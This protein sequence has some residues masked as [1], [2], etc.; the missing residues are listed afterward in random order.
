M[1][2]ASTRP[3]SRIGAPGIHPDEAAQHPLARGNNADAT[4][5]KQRLAQAV[6]LRWLRSAR[7]NQVRPDGD[8]FIWFIR[9]GRGWGKTRVGAEDSVEQARVLGDKC[10][11]ILVG[12]TYSDMRDVMVEG[13]SGILS[14]VPPS[15][16]K[17]GSVEKSW[18]RS[19][20]QLTFANGARIDGYG[21]E[22][23]RKLRGP[24]STGAWGDEP[25]TW[26][27]ADEGLQEDT[28]ISNLMFGC[29]LGPDPRIVL[30]GTP[31]SNPLVKELMSDP[32]VVVTRGSTYDN[33][34]NLAPTF[35]QQVVDA[36]E[37]T[38]LG[39]Q[40]L[41][42]EILDIVEGALWT[43]QML[44]QTRVSIN[45]L[46]H[47]IEIER[48]VVA[49]DPATRTG[50]SKKKSSRDETGIIVVGRGS[51]PPGKRYDDVRHLKHGYILADSSDK[52]TA[53]GWAKQAKA[54]RINWRAEAVVGEVNNGG[55]LV[56]VNLRT[57]D[58]DVPVR[59]V[60]ASRGKV[61]RAEEISALTEKGR[62]HV[63]GY[64][65]KMEDELTTWTAE[66]KW[67]PNRLDAMVWGMWEQLL[68]AGE[69]KSSNPKDRRGKG[70]R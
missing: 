35:R 31:R 1:A 21:A 56:E 54:E 11:H 29:R 36:Y 25:A 46:R 9:S 68:R 41:H 2:R 5:S 7:P 39:R 34:D 44:D 24:Q 66:S 37:G 51:A 17:D 64:L 55:D 13:E 22:K 52:L 18:N 63:V 70:R 42:G 69:A 19:L 67:S 3:R 65:S 62:M 14:I 27:D 10:R 50:S 26:A 33:L 48:V 43:P 47:E 4:I 6:R 57:E 15:L 32:R 40:E 53:R 30:T 38:R 58:P 23:P 49:V 20:G 61:A 16:L 8:W 28:T 45:T 12:Q 59:Q 60:W